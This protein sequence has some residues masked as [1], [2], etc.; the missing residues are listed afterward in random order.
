MG[1]RRCRVGGRPSATFVS[2]ATI[3]AIQ[4]IA[5]GDEFPVRM[6]RGKVG[7][8]VVTWTGECDHGERCP[9]GAECVEYKSPQH[10]NNPQ[11]QTASKVAAAVASGEPTF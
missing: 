10:P 9:F 7:T 6:S 5:V 3:T 2:M 1:V 4:T 11:N 8:A